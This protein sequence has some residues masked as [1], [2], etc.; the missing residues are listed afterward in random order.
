MNLKKDK[1]LSSAKMKKIRKS[2]KMKTPLHQ[3]E[4][5]QKKEWQ[6][7][8]RSSTGCILKLVKEKARCLYEKGSARSSKNMA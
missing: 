1:T 2:S 3:K 8:P 6:K 7:E 4:K 5:P